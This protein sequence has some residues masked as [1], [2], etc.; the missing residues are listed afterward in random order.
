[1]RLRRKTWGSV[2][3]PQRSVGIR[4]LASRQGLTCVHISDLAGICVPRA[5]NPGTHS[6]QYSTVRHPRSGMA[7]NNN[8]APD[9]RSQG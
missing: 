7:G 1:M 6:A 9:L 8:G 5:W 3:P 4:E 2:V